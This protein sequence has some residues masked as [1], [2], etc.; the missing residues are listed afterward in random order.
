MAFILV[1]NPYYPTLT[2]E[3]CTYATRTWLI[4]HKI[5]PCN[6]NTGTCAPTGC[7]AK[8]EQYIRKIPSLS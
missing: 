8:S 6:Q 4:Y 7:G 3:N 2:G 5:S 1:I